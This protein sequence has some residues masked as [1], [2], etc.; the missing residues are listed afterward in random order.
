MVSLLPLSKAIFSGTREKQSNPGRLLVQRERKHT[1]FRRPVR[2]WNALFSLLA[3]QPMACWQGLALQMEVDE[4]RL[5]SL[6]KARSSGH[7]SVDGEPER[8]LSG[9]A[10]SPTEPYR[11]VFILE[12]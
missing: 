7:A 12:V 9:G 8:G 4:L 3:T 6:F 11:I 10:G 2:C 5:S 1:S